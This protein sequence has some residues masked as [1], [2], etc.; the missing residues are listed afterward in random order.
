MTLDE[1]RA[2]RAARP[3][4]QRATIMCP[5]TPGRSEPTAQLADG[6]TMPMGWNMG[7]SIAVGTTGTAEYV[8][9]SNA[10]LWRFTPDP[11]VCPIR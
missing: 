7:Q 11:G 8:S 3:R 9:T 2:Q 4:V 5:G 6:R 1:R 10:G